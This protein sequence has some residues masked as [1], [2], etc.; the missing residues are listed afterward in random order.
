MGAA[1]R[2]AGNIHVVSTAS[3]PTDIPNNITVN[4]FESGPSTTGINANQRHGSFSGEVTTE[5]FLSVEMRTSY[6]KGSFDL[7]SN[8][9][10]KV[11]RAITSGDAVDFVTPETVMLGDV[12]I[13]SG[14]GLVVGFDEVPSGSTTVADTIFQPNLLRLT[15]AGDRTGSLVL[16]DASTTTVPII[17]LQMGFGYG[18][19]QAEGD[20]TIDGDLQ[21]VIN[22]PLPGGHPLEAALYAATIG[23]T[24]DIVTTAPSVPSGDYD[25]NGIVDQGD[26]DLW[27]ITFGNIDNPLADGNNDGVVNLAD[28][29][30]WRDNLGAAGALDGTITGTFD[31]LSI[32]DD[33]GVLAVAGA[34]LRINY[35]SQN[36]VQLEVVAA[37]ALAGSAAVPEPHALAMLLL[38]GLGSAA[39]RRRRK[40]TDILCNHR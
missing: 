12:R 38:G 27:R 19:I 40:S 1:M 17:G 7:S 23:D 8:A 36:L 22:P 20:V 32:V 35:V 5:G 28:Y 2:G 15:E 29:T 37:G 16:E 3:D 33:T 26:Y 18:A 34:T 31:S 9:T 13:G 30:V 21:V 6:I 10:M 4:E 24:F 11:G 14:A 39:F 25:R